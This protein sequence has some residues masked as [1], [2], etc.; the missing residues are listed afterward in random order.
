MVAVHAHVVDVSLQFH[1]HREA[2]YLPIRDDVTVRV[3]VV[4]KRRY[5]LR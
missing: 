2:A 5:G 1:V 4:D 3:V